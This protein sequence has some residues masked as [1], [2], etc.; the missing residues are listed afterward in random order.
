M[1]QTE[2]TVVLT[3]HSQI[4][5]KQAHEI[6]EL[7]GY[8]TRNKYQIVDSSQNPLAFAAEQQKGFLGFIFR[9]YLGHWRKFDMHFFTPKRDLFMIVHHPFRWLFQR[10]E[11]QTSYGQ[12]I[13][14]VQKR[15]S[16]ISKKFDIED[17]NNQVIMSVSSPMWKMW[18]FTFLRR[19]QAVAEIKKKWAGLLS[20]AFT[21]KDNFMVEF[22]D[23]SLT[24]NDRKVILAAAIFIDLQYFERKS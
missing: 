15:F 7:L 20:E 6:A 16:I 10:I 4:F 1:S 8:E 18:T 3:Q 22:R 23:T 13:G 24:E 5:V 12:P 21:D 19:G 11:V 9:Q 2:E 14:A 17:Q